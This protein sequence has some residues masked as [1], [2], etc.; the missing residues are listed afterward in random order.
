M[1]ATLPMYDFPE[2][3][4]ATDAFWAALAKE[5]G[6]SGVLTRDT[7]WTAA[8]R[9]PQLLF[10]QTCGYPFTHEFRG[11]LNYAAT[12]HYAADG[13]EGPNYRSIVFAR[14]QKPLA[15]FEGTT[16]AFNN[17][18]SMSG[19]LALKLMFA[20]FAHRGRFFRDTIET[21]G[22]VASLAAVQ[23]AR[24]DIC[25]IDCVTVAYL[26]RYRPE[27]VE[28]L[29]DVGRSPWVPG[30]PYV[31][32]CGNIEKLRN[33]L[34]AVLHDNDLQE[35]R[36]ALLITDISNIGVPAYDIIPKRETELQARGGLTL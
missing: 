34:V 18:D 1:L 7:D 28:G 32:R 14:E 31:T 15:A 16:A 20:P 35:I 11:V 27:A 10:S 36:S 22:H 12:P 13:C 8:W 21:G 25:A 33:A 24:A 9:N 5:Y 2:L 6:V 30:L 4:E 29:H 3:R 17:Q 23:S 19:M 26:K